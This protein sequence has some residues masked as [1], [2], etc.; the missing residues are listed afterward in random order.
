MVKA[1]RPP[2]DL[3]EPSHNAHTPKHSGPINADREGQGDGGEKSDRGEERRGE[4]RLIYKGGERKRERK[5]L[6]MQ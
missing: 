1:R 5:A 2:F 6:S 3:H 4:E